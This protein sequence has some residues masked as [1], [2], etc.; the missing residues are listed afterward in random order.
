[1]KKK[2]IRTG[3]AGIFAGALE[4]SK[5]GNLDIKQSKLFDDVFIKER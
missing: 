2:Q 3:T 1:M 5:E 4:L